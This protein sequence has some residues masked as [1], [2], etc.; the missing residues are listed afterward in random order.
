M[1]VRAQDAFPH[2]LLEES[3]NARLKY[4]KELTVK[5]PLLSSANDEL[6][7]AVRDSKPGT[8]IF[9]QGPAGVGKSTLLGKIEARLTEK[10]L[11][12]LTEDRER[13]PVVKL[14]LLAPITG[15]FDWKDYYRE[16]LTEMEEPLIDHKVD[17]E[18]LQGIR[19]NSLTGMKSN[20]QLLDNDRTGVRP[21]RFASF[22][23]LKH[24]KPLAVL[25]DDAQHFGIVSSGRRLIDQLNAVKTQADKTLITQVLCG[26]YELAPLRNLNGQLSRRS[27]DIHFRRYQATDEAQ[28]AEFINALYTFQEHLPLP[29]TP[30][31]ISHWDYFY[32][33]SIGCVGV[34]KDWLTQSLALAIEDKCKTLSMRHV[35]QR[36]LSVTQC[37]TMLREAVIGEKEFEEREEARSLLR[38]NLGLTARPL[39]D[40]PQNLHLTQAPATIQQRRRRHV[41]RRKPKRDKIGGRA[42]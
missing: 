30:D 26:T 10:A 35:E 22:Q 1:N 4:F 5:H 31:L 16:L 7:C 13:I 38:Q 24:R 19:L 11:K 40:T 34:L 32:E 18:K 2:H 39:Q 37:A 33:R 28:R 25:I 20:R 6:W 15:S 8:I 29:K 42:A 3:G 27:L 23:T 41:G 21:L 36:A 12:N 9:L 17:M 14:Q